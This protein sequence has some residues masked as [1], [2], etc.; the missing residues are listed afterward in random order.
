MEAFK[1]E[2]IFKDM[3]KTELEEKSYPSKLLP[4]LLK[5]TLPSILLGRLKSFVWVKGLIQGVN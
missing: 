4:T 3:I 5:W 1:S 2:H